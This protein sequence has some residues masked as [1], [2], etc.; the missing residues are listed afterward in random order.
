LEQNTIPL[1]EIGELVVGTILRIAPYGAYV[2]LDEYGDIEGLMHISEIASSWIKN[3]RDHVREGQKTVLK[4]LRVDPIKIHVDVS[5]RRVNEKERK[6]KLLQWK[7]EIRGRN[8]LEIAAE[9]MNASPEEAYEKIGVVIE[10]HFGSIYS[11]LEIAAEQGISPLIDVKIT[12]DWATILVEI[13]KEKVRVPK[14][15]SVGTLELSC[16]KPNGVNILKK[17]FKKG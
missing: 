4:V 10:D 5:L 7:R 6:E 9:K 3:I 15:K 2:T 11:G 1:P 14:S 17:A 16:Y 12:E 13:A 8:L